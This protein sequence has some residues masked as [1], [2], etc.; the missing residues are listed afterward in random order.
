MGERALLLGVRLGREDDVRVLV[1]RVGHEVGERDHA[2]GASSARPSAR[3][4]GA[5]R[6]GSA[7][8]STAWSARRR[9][10]SAISASAGPAR[11]SARPGPRFGRQ[12]TSRSPRAFVPAGTSISPDLGLSGDAER[13]GHGEQRVDRLRAALAV[14]QALA[15]ERSRRR[16]R[17][18]ERLGR[19]RGSVARLGAGARAPGREPSARSEPS[20]RPARPARPRR[21]RARSARAASRVRVE[22]ARAGWS[23]DDHAWRRCGAPPCARAGRG[24]APRPPARS[25]PPAPRRRSRCR[26]PRADRSGRASTRACSGSSGAAGARVDVRRAERPRASGAGAGSPPRWWPRRRPA[27]RSAR[28]PCSSAAAASSARAPT[29]PRAATPPSRTIGACMRSGEW[30]AW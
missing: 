29:R 14:R 24:S 26:R 21:R 11:A 9:R 2:G 8:S 3:G 23:S 4:R 1:E 30:I 28:R 15:P 22:R 12:P 16:R 25:R 13:G 17:R 5:S 10:P 27:R 18:V 19:G 7:C 20:R 6:S